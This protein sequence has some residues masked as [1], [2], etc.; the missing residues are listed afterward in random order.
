MRELPPNGQLG[1][2]W[3]DERFP[4]LWEDEGEEDQERKGKKNRVGE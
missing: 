1:N 2:A 4:G 3:L